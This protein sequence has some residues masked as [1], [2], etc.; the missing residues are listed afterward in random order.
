[1]GDMWHV[2]RHRIIASAHPVTRRSHCITRPPCSSH[3][4]RTVV[5]HGDT[6]GTVLNMSGKR[7]RHT[8]SPMWLGCGC[9]PIA[10]GRGRWLITGS[11]NKRAVS[12]WLSWCRNAVLQN[13]TSR[14]SLVAPTSLRTGS[15][16]LAACWPSSGPHHLLSANNLRH[17]II[18]TC[19]T[20]I[21]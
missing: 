21:I 13:C 1:M 7:Y 20:S 12:L 18:K 17:N 10:F 14:A 4:Q 3:F 9:A 16:Q 5:Q 8:F 2:V 19:Q 6:V 15:L 11:G